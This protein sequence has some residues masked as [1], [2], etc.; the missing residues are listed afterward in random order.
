MDKYDLAGKTILVTG[1]NGNIGK[2]VINACIG[3]GANVIKT[4]LH[5]EAENPTSYIKCNM[6]ESD[7]IDFLVSKIPQLDGVICCSGYTKLVPAGF[8]HEK[9]VDR[10][11]DLNLKSPIVLINKLL[12]K[13][14]INIEASIV[15]LASSAA[16]NGVVGN[17]LYSAAKAG[18]VSIVKVWAKELSKKRIRCN[19]ISPGI[20]ETEMLMQHHDEEEIKLMTKA[21]PLGM[22]KVEDIAAA[23]E[24]LVSDSSK[25]VTGTNLIVDGGYLIK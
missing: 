24:Y 20:I 25:W 3:D 13:K 8:Y 21:N 17:G 2:A 22:G 16:V 1:A 14:K 4:D 11:I 6:L 18:L 23:A 15:L 12:K 19:C 9:D 10:I 5:E 7:E